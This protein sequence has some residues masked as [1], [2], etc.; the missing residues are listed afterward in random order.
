M[1][2]KQLKKRLGDAFRLRPLPIRIDG[3]GQTIPSS[4]DKW[5]FDQLLESPQRIRLVN[6]HTEHFIEL[7]PDNVREYRSPDFLL[8]RC[9]LIVRGNAIAIEPMLGSNVTQQSVFARLETQMSALL[10]EMR[11]DLT[12][13]PLAR[14]FVVLKRSWVY[15][16]KGNELVYYLDDH[17]DLTNQ[18]HILAN[19]ELV[20]EITYNRT[21][22]YIISE[23]LAEYLAG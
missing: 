2:L 23:R 12:K 14:E 3:S 5:R 21:T 20:E 18:L 6:I 1:N 7:Q 16:A 9:Q 11:Q 22:R 15:W 13:N 8:L 17:P 10:A 4:D 19:Q